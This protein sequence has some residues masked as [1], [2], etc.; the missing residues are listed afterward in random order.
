MKKAKCAYDLAGACFSFNQTLYEQNPGLY[1]PRKPIFT[2][3]DIKKFCISKKGSGGK[4]GAIIGGVLGALAGLA[5]LAALAVL[6]ATKLRQ[7]S[8]PPPGSGGPGAG[9]AG[10]ASQNPIYSGAQAQTN[11][12]W[13][14]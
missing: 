8:T 7:Q 2:E 13:T 14:T 4:T 6:A 3:G 11:P 1:G 12:L 5:A 9:A 10:A